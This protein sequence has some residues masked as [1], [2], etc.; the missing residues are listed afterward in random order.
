[1]KFHAQYCNICKTK[2]LFLEK[3]VDPKSDT[4]TEMEDICQTC[5]NEFFVKEKIKLKV[6]L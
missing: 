2:T 5:K 6:K 1:M 3:L 4:C